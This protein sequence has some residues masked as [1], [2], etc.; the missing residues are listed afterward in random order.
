MG[1]SAS[2]LRG[3]KI[4]AAARREIGEAL[5]RKVHLFL[6][7]KARPGWQDEAARYREIGLEFSDGGA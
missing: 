2:I 4:G 3:L 1:A 5:G 6:Q 7:V